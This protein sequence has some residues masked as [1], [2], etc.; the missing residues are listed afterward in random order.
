MTLQLEMITVDSTDAETLARW[1]AEQLGATVA[2]THDGWFVILSGGG[3]PLA[4]AFQKV[5]EV[6]PGKNRIH[7]DLTAEDIEAETG[8]LADA[9]ATLLGR[10]GDE[11]FRWVTMADPQGNQFD[12]A[13]ASDTAE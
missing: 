9:G 7:L 11:D 3:L 10:H 1:W 13:Q 5:E 6:T 8:R 12:V 4:L 2:E